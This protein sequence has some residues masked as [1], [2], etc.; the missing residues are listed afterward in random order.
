MYRMLTDAFNDSGI[1]WRACHREDRGD[2]ALI[3]VPPSIPTSA[4]VDAAA[5]LAAALGRHNRQV[6]AATRIYQAEPAR[7][8]PA[9]G[10][11]RVNQ[12]TGVI[13]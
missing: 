12:D 6:S 10:I 7:Q 9:N 5:L 1:R 2:G 8:A 11:A 3:I 4:V 13:V